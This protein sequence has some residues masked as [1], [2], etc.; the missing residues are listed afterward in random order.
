MNKLA[1]SL[2]ILGFIFGC[3]KTE[4]IEEPSPG[5]TVTIKAGDLKAIFVDN[6]PFD[7]HMRYLNGAAFLSHKADSKNLFRYGGL[8][9]EHIFDG[10]KWWETKEEFFEP[11][12]SPLKIKRISEKTAELYQSLSNLHKL[13]SWTRFTVREP[14][15]ID[16]DFT[17]IPRAETFDRGYIGLFWA[18]YINTRA[19]REYYFIGHRPGEKKKEW[20][21]LLPSSHMGKNTVRYENDDR[22]P[23]FIENYPPRL[24][25]N[26]SDYVYS[27]PFY[28]GKRGEMVY[29]IMFEQES[30]VRF[31][32]SPTSGMPM[33]PD[34]SP[35]WDFHFLFYDYKVGE[36]YGFKARVVYKP[37]ISREDIIQE[38]ENWSGQ[39]V[40]NMDE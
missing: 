40:S 35:A 20:I 14:H 30:S 39:K 25:N 3:G 9:Y 37:F 6:S 22:D 18:S 2:I 19:D 10:H 13:E 23:T 17:C 4:K 7:N 15:Y 34:A 32:H 33:G 29:A 36:K 12:V 11:R 26:Y 27:Y 1:I 38:Y 5:H 24:F 16:M 8:N 28:Y 31:T 21:K